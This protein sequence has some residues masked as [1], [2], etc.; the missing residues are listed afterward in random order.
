MIKPITTRQKERYRNDLYEEIE[1]NM[2]E[3]VLAILIIRKALG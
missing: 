3:M 1:V 2:L